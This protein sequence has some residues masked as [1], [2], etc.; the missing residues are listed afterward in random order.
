MRGFAAPSFG[1][2]PR[3]KTFANE[4]LSRKV[5]STHHFFFFPVL[6]LFGPRPWLPDAC[7]VCTGKIADP[8]PVASREVTESKTKSCTQDPIWSAPEGAPSRVEPTSNDPGGSLRNPPPASHTV[9]RNDVERT[10]SQR[11]FEQASTRRRC[12]GQSQTRRAGT[13][14]LWPT[15]LLCSAVSGGGACLR[16]DDVIA[17]GRA[18]PFRTPS[19]SEPNIGQGLR[20]GVRLPRKRLV[21]GGRDGTR[22]LLRGSRPPDCCPTSYHFPAGRVL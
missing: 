12:Q 14:P 2:L 5:R 18:N 17:C 4:T 3:G 6:F 8:S 22:I 11:R 7:R 15:L 21:C 16:Y 10:W 13:A 19:N 1:R 20:Q 9:E